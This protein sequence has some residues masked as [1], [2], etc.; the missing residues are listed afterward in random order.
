MFVKPTNGSPVNY[1]LGEL[2]R[3]NPNTSFPK[4]I[5]DAILESYGIYR[6]KE[7]SAPS[8]NGK[9]HRA[10]QSVQ[11]VDGQ[12][13]QV[14]QI[15][16]ASEDEASANMRRHRNF[17]LNETDYFA[18]TDVTMNAAMTSYRQALRDITTHANWPYLNDED[19][20]TKPEQGRD[21]PLK[22][23]TANGAIIVTAEDGSGDAAVTFPRSGYVEPTHTGNVNITGDLTTTGAVGITG[24]VTTTGAVDITGDVDV[25]GSFIADTY[26]ETYAG[27]GI[28]SS[29]VDIDLEDGNVFAGTLIG[30][31][32]FTFS[33]PPAYLTAYSFTLNVGVLSGS[34]TITWPTSVLWAGG[35]APD[36]PASGEK[37]VFV[38]ITYEAGITWYGFQAGDAMA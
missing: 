23:N 16:P 35:T 27:L 28:L 5:P 36:A 21:M 10:T 25:T 33:N 15:V 2:R 24:N 11:L 34:H 8:F 14:W 17:L 37:D 30:N 1:T 20:P 18:L 3:D 38:F 13:T 4:Q 31:T 7:V 26:N 12:W 22:F 9:T 32:T 6:V 29:T 19:W